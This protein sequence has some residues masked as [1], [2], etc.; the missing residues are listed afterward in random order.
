MGLLCW[1][2]LL[3]PRLYAPTAC[4]NVETRHQNEYVAYLAADEAVRM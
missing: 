3:L 1:G 4:N 2:L